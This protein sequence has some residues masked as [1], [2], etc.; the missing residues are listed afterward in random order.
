MDDMNV[1]D[2]LTAQPQKISREKN[3]A[4]NR[5]YGIEVMKTE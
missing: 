1:L 3:G 5:K 4:K 2:S